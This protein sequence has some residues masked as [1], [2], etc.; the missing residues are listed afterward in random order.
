[1]AEIKLRDLSI[2]IFALIGILVY[3]NLKIRNYDKILAATEIRN[4][5]MNEL[6]KNANTKKFL[7]PKEKIFQKNRNLKR[8]ISEI[9]KKFSLTS[10]LFK[11]I[12]SEKFKLKFEIH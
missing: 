7:K 11:E 10:V 9:F 8:N 5:K 3:Q 12:S 1:M 6:Q 2:I 4:T